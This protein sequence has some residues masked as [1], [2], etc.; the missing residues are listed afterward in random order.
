MSRL[1][2]SFCVLGS[3]RDL[4]TAVRLRPRL[5]AEYV[6]LEQRIGHDFQHGRSIASIIE[7][8]TR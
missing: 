3:R 2:C 7:E 4:V 8:A 5:A 6:A 1:S